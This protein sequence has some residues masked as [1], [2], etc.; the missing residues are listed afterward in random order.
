M[1]DQ[2]HPAKN[3]ALSLA[4]AKYYFKLMAY[5]DEFEVA[6]L[7]TSKYFK[8]YLNERLEGDYKIEYSLAPPIFGGKDERTGRYPKI[9]LPSFFYYFFFLL[10]QFKF[11]RGT[12]F[13]YFW[14]FSSQKIRKTVN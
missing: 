7:H 9:N 5:K 8:E 3:S 10:K 12:I 1:I 14:F 6:R 11:L 2:E 13:K 4:V